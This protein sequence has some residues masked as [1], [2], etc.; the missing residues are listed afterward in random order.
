MLFLLKGIK[1]KRTKN[2]KKIFLTLALIGLSSSAFAGGYRVALQGVRQAAL[3]G[4]SAT[5]T[6]D[7]SVAFYNPAGLAFVESKLS[8]AVGGFGVKTDVRWQDA[9]T[10]QKAKTDSKLGTPMYLAVSYKPADDVAIGL[11]VTTPFGSSVTWPEDWQNKSNIT[12]IDLKVFNIQPTI[13]Y[14]FNDWFSI[15]AGFIYTHGSAKLEKIQTV[16][17]NDIK[18]KLEDKDAHGLGFNIGAMFKPTDKFGLGLA[19]RSNVDVSANKGDVTWTNVPTGIASNVPFNTDKWNTTLPLPS[20]FTFGMSY[21]ILPKLE[22]FGDIVWQNWTRYKSLDINLYND[23][24]HTFYTSSSQKNWKDNTLFRFGAEYAFTENIHGRVGYYH[25][26]SPVPA[27][28]WSSETPSSNL[29]SFSAG[30]G[31]KLNSGFNI[32]L[33]GSYVQGDERHINN[34]EQNFQGDVKMRAINFGLGVSYNLK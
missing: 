3:G 30:L 21:K 10:L 6:H 13:A 26:K 17:G 34:I 14:R 18:L 20:E 28:Y 33:F 5:Q 32:D 1:Y 9:T 29:N 22:I 12:H 24:S 7:A 31:F 4:T 23:A 8:I 16:A 19:Y 15:G 27:S 11:S 2:M 25:D